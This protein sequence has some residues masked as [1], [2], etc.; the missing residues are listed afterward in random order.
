MFICLHTVG[1]VWIPSTDKLLSL[2]PTKLHIA[3]NELNV[4]SFSYFSFCSMER[5]L[6]VCISGSGD[7][8]N[9]IGYGTRAYSSPSTSP[10]LHV[11][12]FSHVMHLLCVGLGP[13]PLFV[14]SEVC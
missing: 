6:C 11:T 14:L 2:T 13:R 10:L 9:I 12:L 5:W 3:V 7:R 1:V 8:S 4:K